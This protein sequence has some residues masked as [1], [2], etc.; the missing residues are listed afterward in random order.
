MTR[1]T[2]GLCLL[3]VW[4]GIY[5][6]SLGTTEI[7]GEE[8]RRIMPAVAMIET[9]NWLVPQLAGEAYLRKPPLI[10]WAIAASMRATG[11]RSEWAARLPSVLGMLAL[12][13][14][15]VFATAGWLRAEGALMAAIFSIGCIGLIEKGRLAEIEAL[16]IAFTGL[17]I[18]WWMRGF[19]TQA[20]RWVTWLG[21]GLL[22]GLGL[23]TK[24]PQHLLFF[25]TV[26]LGVCWRARSAREIFNIPHLAGLLVAAA[27]FASWMVPYLAAT[28]SGAAAS[29][30]QEQ[31]VE[32]F[33]ENRFDLESW[34]L[35]LPRGLA[36]FLPWVVL[37]PLLWN[38]TAVNALPSRERL[39]FEGT[40]NATV[41]VYLG[42]LLIPGMLVRYSMPF[43][44]VFGVMLA[45]VLRDR[46]P[47]LVARWGRTTVLGLAGI[48]A[49]GSLS[50][51]FAGGWLA[52]SV[53][54]ALLAALICAAV[55]RQRARLHTAPAL[56]AA[57]AALIVAIALIYSVAVVPR[58][59]AEDDV[60]PVA[61][62]LAAAIPPGET[63]HIID[64][65]YQPEL[66]YLRTPHRY[67]DEWDHVPEEARW[68]LV[69]SRKQKEALKHRPGLKRAGEFPVKLDKPLLLLHSAS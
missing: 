7:K 4:A 23:L 63:L 48:L 34:L 62:A 22:L 26:V 46:L 14:G 60:R 65:G 37:V 44:P 3:L 30:W 17:A 13:L 67:E 51:P 31:L 35:A 58:M 43:L 5:L 49:I 19:Q 36:N 42:M 6:P 18:V 1:V 2:A 11:S 10:N 66:F 68:F 32:R 40:R 33:T 61:A 16:Y 53:A 50:S 24:G 27:I 45:W 64:I 8:G 41:V 29:T 54:Q 38:R 12:G 55:W 21:C 9:G 28:E 57:S 56:A 52:A 15:I 25:Y 20:S 47:P 69:R 39:L 59:V